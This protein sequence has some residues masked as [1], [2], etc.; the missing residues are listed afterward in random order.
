MLTGVEEM[1]SPRNMILVCSMVQRNY[2]AKDPSEISDFEELEISFAHAKKTK[3][4]TNL[5][6]C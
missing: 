5:I 1:A 3:D 4:V 2:K 6:A